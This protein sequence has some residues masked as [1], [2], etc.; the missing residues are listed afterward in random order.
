MDRWAAAVHEM[1]MYSILHTDGLLPDD[2]VDAIAATALAAMK[3]I[4]PVAGMDIRHVKDI[5]GD[6]LAVCGNVDCGL[7]LTG[8]PET[9]WEATR[10]LLTTCKQ[11]GGLVL[12]ASNAVQP[13]A[14]IDNYRA[15]IQAWRDHGQY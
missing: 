9:V 4:D 11:G 2:Y 13:E 8:P 12:G 14:P 15:M 7:L 5:V 1:G 10:E 3:A 6:R